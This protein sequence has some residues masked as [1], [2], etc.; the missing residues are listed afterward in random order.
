M[1]KH[2]QAAD[3]S[4]LVPSLDTGIRTARDSDH[5][6]I[7]PSHTAAAFMASACAGYVPGNS[8]SLNQVFTF[9]PVNTKK[10]YLIQIRRADTNALAGWVADESP[11]F[12]V[13]RTNLLK[14]MDAKRAR[15]QEH[16]NEIEQLEA[17]IE[18]IDSVVDTLDGF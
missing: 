1:T 16:R 4:A 18:Q 8:A 10:G 6:H 3:H 13:A 9:E 14:Q 17:Q 12:E 11:L 7:F 5:A 15:I 2:A